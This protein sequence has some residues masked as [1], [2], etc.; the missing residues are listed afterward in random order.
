MV[1][2]KFRQIVT[3]RRALWA[4]VALAADDRVFGR[5]C[6]I[7]DG[8]LES[9]ANRAGPA[10]RQLTIR[11]CDELT[12]CGLNAVIAQQCETAEGKLANVE[13]SDCA[14][15]GLQVLLD[16]LAGC[17]SL[18]H[19]AIS[20]CGGPTAAPCAPGA[21]A[22]HPH[23]SS[24]SRLTH[25]KLDDAQYTAPEL[26]VLLQRCP[27]LEHLQ[28][29]A[30]PRSMAGRLVEVVISASI[31]PQ[32][33]TLQ[34]GDTAYRA[35]HW[36]ESSMMEGSL[37]TSAM[38]AFGA[39]SASASASA[40]ANTDGDMDGG[41]GLLGGAL[42]IVDD[43]MV[44]G[45]L[46]RCVSTTGSNSVLTVLEL[47]GFRGLNGPALSAIPS[48]I[49]QL[50]LRGCSSLESL[51]LPLCGNMLALDLEECCALTD[52]TLIAVGRQCPQLVEL[53]VE[54]CEQLTDGAIYGSVEAGGFQGLK[55]INI[56]GCPLV[57]SAGLFMLAQAGAAQSR[58]IGMGQLTHVVVGFD[59]GSVRSLNL[60][61][62][63][64]AIS[65]AP[66]LSNFVTG[67]GQGLTEATAAVWR[68]LAPIDDDGL[69]SLAS[70]S[71]LT[72]LGM[73]TMQPDSSMPPCHAHVCCVYQRTNVE[74]LGLCFLC[75]YFRMSSDWRSDS[76]THWSWWINGASTTE[77]C[78]FYAAGASA[79]E[80]SWFWALAYIPTSNSDAN[81]DYFERMPGA[82]VCSNNGATG[83]ITA[84]ATC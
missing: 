27:L 39:G 18:L 46:Q 74:T 56:R 54:G 42:T 11:G 28:I 64:Q 53:N 7:V 82:G 72:V 63:P 9:L 3:R 29:F 58:T 78:K 51:P 22:Q 10:L 55:I 48:S 52:S 4:N 84:F 66:P 61:L 44:Q 45:L 15:V 25:L 75:R 30:P 77:C 62:P 57:T 17:S 8:I 47:S 50:S 70:I 24:R 81:V 71:P 65:A 14:W 36:T 60:P 2:R 68:W 34:L 6:A 59:S 33:Q 49:V 76:C 5:P 13:L 40:T 38:A 23:P 21:T 31:A 43:T 73:R 83:R 1:C 12:A 19:L 67:Q 69:A 35:A 79:V 37:D 16:L 80:L 20:G 32:L 41:H 26:H